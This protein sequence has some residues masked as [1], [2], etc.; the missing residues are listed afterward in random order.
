MAD[1]LSQT[2]TAV[3]LSCTRQSLMGRYELRL[4]TSEP[5]LTTYFH[6]KHTSSAV[7]SCTLSCHFTPCCSG[8]VISILPSARVLTRPLAT[9]GTSLAKTG[10]Y[11][12]LSL[13]T[14]SPSTIV[15]SMSVRNWLVNAL[16]LSTS[17]P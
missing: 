8:Q 3:Y 11:S 14:I 12:F 10:M 13:L 15:S 1:G 4:Y 6:V 9:V 17:A 16:R 2:I 5:S 7:N